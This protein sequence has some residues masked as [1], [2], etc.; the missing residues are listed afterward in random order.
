MSND[1]SR[2][3]K[4]IS[5]NADIDRIYNSW[6]SQAELE[7]WFLRKAEFTKPNGEKLGREEFIQKGCSYL[8]LWHGYSDD[9][10][11]RGTILEANG[12]N[13]IKFV[14]G[15]AGIVT[16]RIKTEENENIVEL[17]QEDIPT[18]EKS[19]FNYHVGCGEGWT[20]YLANL[21]SFLEGGIDLRNKNINV[22][23]VISS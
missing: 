16:V 5:I 23:K 20:F 2:F 13:L 19:K 6:S 18:D 3:V 15:K 8:W 12:K 9:T 17:I 21:K 4:R 1:W 22:K 7:K 11:E 14:F 10:D